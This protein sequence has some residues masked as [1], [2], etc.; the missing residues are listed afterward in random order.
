MNHHF[1]SKTFSVSA[2]LV[3]VLPLQINSTFIKNNNI[4]LTSQIT[5][6]DLQIAASKSACPPN[7]TKIINNTFELTLDQ[8]K[9]QSIL[10]YTQAI[11][12][13]P[14]CPY[15][16]FSRGMIYEDFLENWQKAINDYTKAISLKP[17]YQWAYYRR[18]LVYKR[19]NNYEKANE[20]LKEFARLDKLTNGNKSIICPSHL[21]E[22]ASSIDVISSDNEVLKK[23]VEIYTQAI[24]NY[25]NCNSL[26]FLRGMCYHT[27]ENWE[28]AIDDYTRA[29]S[30]NPD[31]LWAYYRRALIY[32][33]LNSFD[34]AIDDL[35]QTIRLKPDH[36]QF[37]NDRGVA[38]LNV[39]KY[40]D[41]IKDIDRAIQ[42][43]PMNPQ[44]YQNRGL[45]YTKLGKQKEAEE[46]FQIAAMLLS[47]GPVT[48]TEYKTQGYESIIYP[49]NYDSSS[50]EAEPDLTSIL[51]DYNSLETPDTSTDSTS[52][53][54]EITL[55]SARGF[56][57]T[58]LRDLLAKKKWK[59]ADS[60]TAMLLLSISKGK[61]EY[62]LREEDFTSL[63]C[64][65]LRIMDKLWIAYSQGK[66]GFSVQRKI[67]RNLGGTAEY[68]KN[69]WINFIDKVGWEVY[70]DINYSFDH[71]GKIGNLPQLYILPVGGGVNQADE[72][73]GRMSLFLGLSLVSCEL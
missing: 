42:I 41:A 7:L 46:N 69:I 72:G 35:T 59:E 38:Y 12:S 8:R 17:D 63:S 73:V 23:G 47:I 50:S 60:E 18:H 39:G 10:L 58:G 52:I 71:M 68:D 31:Y 26:Y 22:I 44:F 4:K 62:Y 9:T 56:D 36:A 24:L 53:S 30:L 1:P 64:E 29:I 6:T 66:F 21:T 13:Y 32:F 34:K 5:V 67:Y 43:G 15:L 27:L 3:L 19:L 55:V 37:Y 48:I 25:P 51:P 49:D 16:Y 70:P 54:E 14:S 2:F 65:D 61:N 33:E 11:E 20:D 40:E 45:I 57:Y 28:K